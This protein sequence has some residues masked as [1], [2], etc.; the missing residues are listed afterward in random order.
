M[1]ITTHQIPDVSLFMFAGNA[2]F[3]LYNTESG[4]R[5]T[6]RVRQADAKEEGEDSHSFSLFPT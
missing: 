5:I 2:T 6:Y 3:T 1:D 4:N